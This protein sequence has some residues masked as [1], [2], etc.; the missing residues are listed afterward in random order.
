[1][2]NKFSQTGVESLKNFYYSSLLF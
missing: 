1:V 2:T